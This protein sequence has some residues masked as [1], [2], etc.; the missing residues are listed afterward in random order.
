MAETQTVEVVLSRDDYD[1]L[2]AALRALGRPAPAGFA[3]LI[4]EGARHYQADQRA[5]HQHVAGGAD[6]DP[7]ARELQRREA[8]GH[9]IL[10][11]VRAAELEARMNALRS[12]VADLSPRYLRL[13]DR[14]FALQRERQ[15]IA[16]RQARGESLIGNSAPRPGSPG[17]RLWGWLVGRRG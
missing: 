16:T 17:S 5:W 14:L 12:T 1:R 7:A 10:M 11:R 13:R 3:W 4:A 9:L 6:Q 15:A 2:E 8:Q